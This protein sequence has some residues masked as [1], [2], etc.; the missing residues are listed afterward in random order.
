LRLFYG[1]VKTKGGTLAQGA[2][3]PQFA[4]VHFD[5]AFGDGKPQA[6]SGDVSDVLI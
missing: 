4:A 3:E 5:H 1:E 6:G 2:I